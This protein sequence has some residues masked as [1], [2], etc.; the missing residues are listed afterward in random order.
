[1]AQQLAHFNSEA[2][3]TSWMYAEIDDDC[4]DNYRF[5][6]EDDAE[7]VTKYEQARDEGCCGRFDQDIYV[8]GRKA[9]IGCNYGH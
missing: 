4:I 9:M 1:M 5:A 2:G 3:A 8:A 7:A 6:F